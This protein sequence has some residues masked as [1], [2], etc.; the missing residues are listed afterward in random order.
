[1][2]R[3]SVESSNSLIITLT[4][5]ALTFAAGNQAQAITLGNT[6]ASGPFV[7]GLGNEAGS[8]S[9]NNNGDFLAVAVAAVADNGNLTSDTISP[10]VTYNGV[11]LT[12]AASRQRGGREW[13]GLFY[14]ANPAI[15]SNSLAVNFGDDVLTEPGNGA[16]EIGAVSLSGVD[17]TDPIAA[18][19]STESNANPLSLPGLPGAITPGDFLLLASGN[20]SSTGTPTYTVPT[21]SQ[22]ILFDN[23]NPSNTTGGRSYDSIF[24]TL[25]AGDIDSDAVSLG[26]EEHRSGAHAAVVFNSLPEPEPPVVPEPAT[27]VLTGLAG[28]A[29]MRRR[30]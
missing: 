8:F 25:A 13:V 3:A 4:A 19:L 9:F 26:G 2:T 28:V 24:A 18:T 12:S 27:L 14:L 5:A 11:P 22:T 6:G 30:R 21:D 1:M 7:A 29:L 20:D 16:W 23:D 10:T 17:E 15:G